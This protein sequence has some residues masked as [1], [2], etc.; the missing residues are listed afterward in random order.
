[1]Q[2]RRTYAR[3]LVVLLISI[4]V[5][6]LLQTPA[7]AKAKGPTAAQIEAFRQMRDAHIAN[8]EAE[9]SLVS[10]IDKVA[11]EV[12]KRIAAQARKSML[13]TMLPI[14]DEAAKKLTDDLANIAGQNPY[15]AVPRH[16][17]KMVMAGTKEEPA[18]RVRLLYS[19]TLLSQQIS[20]LR[21]AQNNDTTDGDLDWKA[22][23][24]TITILHNGY[25][26][27]AVWGADIDG[28]PVKDSKANR[29][30]IVKIRLAR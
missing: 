11:A 24:G 1:M 3:V 16:T 10:Q 4:L 5:S 9:K 15:I 30:K 29:A 2:M 28:H 22:E 6:P 7:I 13:S 23:P 12:R 14:N 26:L 17:F 25:D 19:T 18:Q 27:A 21:Y 20:N 8:T